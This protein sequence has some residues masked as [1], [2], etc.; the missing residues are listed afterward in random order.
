MGFPSN[1]PTS[2]YSFYEKDASLL[3]RTVI[4]ATAYL[5][6][7]N[8]VHRDIKPENLIFKTKNGLSDLLIA[9]FGLSKIMD[10]SQYDVLMTTCGTPGYMAPEVI[11]KTGHG[12]PVDMWSIGVLTYF[13]YVEWLDAD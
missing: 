3:V 11:R 4:A 13:L 6:S 10:P 9:D 1:L 2:R 12:K 8:I 7:Q 5:H